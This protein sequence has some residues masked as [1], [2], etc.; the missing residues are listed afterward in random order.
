MKTQERIK[1]L[2]LL[3][4]GYEQ[5]QVAQIVGV[6]EKTVGNWA[7]K[8]RT[9]LKLSKSNIT[10]LETRLNTMLQDPKAKTT[11]IKNLVLSLNTLRQKT[12]QKPE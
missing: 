6:T 10:L 9:S 2:E 1:A 5:K 8:Y 7:K 12:P 11:D 3:D 4:K